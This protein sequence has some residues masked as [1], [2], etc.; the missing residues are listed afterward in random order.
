MQ[1]KYENFFLVFKIIAF[2]LLS[3]IPLTYEENTRDQLS[4]C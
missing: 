3:E 2:E 1:Q 4:M